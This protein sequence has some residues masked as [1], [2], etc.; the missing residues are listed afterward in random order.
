MSAITELAAAIDHH[1]SRPF[2]IDPAGGR[3]L[4]H[5][6]SRER[7]LALASA[8]RELGLDRGDRLAV[9]LPNSVELALVYQAA[10]LSGIV[11]VRWGQA[12]GG[13][14]FA[15]SCCAPGRAWPSPDQRR[16]PWPQSP[17]SS[18]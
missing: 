13:A 11:I 18:T 8:L 16:R 2:L 9:S 5:G 6:E 14:S 3:E 15:T 4:T 7:A 17:T 10:L 12:S 1:A